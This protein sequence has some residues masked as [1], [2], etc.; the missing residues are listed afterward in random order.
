MKLKLKIDTKRILSYIFITF[1]TS[2]LITTVL[3][4]LPLTEKL[5]TKTSFNLNLKDES[6]WSKEYVIE[7]NTTDQKEIEKTRDL[8]QRRLKAFGVEESS[9]YKAEKGEKTSTMRVVV[10]TTRPEQLVA[11]LIQNRFEVKI[12][13]KKDDAN[14]EDPENPYAYLMPTSYNDTEWDHSDFRNIYITRLKT[15]NGN[16]AY[17]AIFKPWPWK[18]N[19]FKELIS[20]NKGKYLGVYTDGY[21][22][23]YPVPLDDTGQGIFA[24]PINTDEKI[25]IQ[26]IDILYNT[27]I[28]TTDLSLKSE[29]DLDLQTT[30][31]DHIKISIGLALSLVV[32]YLYL[33]I[34]K[35]T[36]KDI[37]IESFLSTV[38]TI[39]SYLT[40]L[41]LLG[42]PVDSIMLPIVAMLAMIITRVIS[43]NGES[44]KYI[45]FG[46]TTTMLLTYLLGF[47]YLPIFATHMASVILL[48][49]CFV[50]FS[51]WY[52]YKV[53]NI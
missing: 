44:N 30:S 40:L 20:Q 37:L 46:L 19:A 23:P 51:K 5:T 3:I 53:R 32:I 45:V 26:A 10:T 27:G 2:L 50:P 34:F 6:Y 38:L 11:Q 18:E 52:I 21:V 1:V 41:K 31:L 29:T 33:A 4:A 24:V 43:E 7:L 16:Y 47:G 8:L 28:I 42:I 9:I 39:S 15:N 49:I 13:S 48:I 22:S 12:V 36:T 35:H 17:F 14:F 25:Q